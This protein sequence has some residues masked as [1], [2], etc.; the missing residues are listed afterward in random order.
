VWPRFG[1]SAVRWRGHFSVSCCWVLFWTLRSPQGYSS[2]SDVSFLEC[3]F[4]LLLWRI[5]LTF[6]I[7]HFTRTPPSAAQGTDEHLGLL[8]SNASCLRKVSGSN[9]YPDTDCPHFIRCVIFVHH[10]FLGLIF[11]GSILWWSLLT[12]KLTINYKYLKF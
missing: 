5:R 9:L 11:S 7:L 1:L 12:P 8:A 6:Y 3:Q 2:Q 4:C 10:F